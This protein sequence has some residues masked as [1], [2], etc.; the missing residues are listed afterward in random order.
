MLEA[1]QLP[2]IAP[3]GSEKKNASI[4]LWSSFLDGNKKALSS[5]YH[6]YY[7][8]LY[9]YGLRLIH[10]DELIKDSIQ[11]LF[12]YMWE[13]HTS[14]NPVQSVKSY[15]LLSLRRVIFVNIQRDKS[16]YIRNKQ[17]V[18]GMLDDHKNIED[19][20]ISKDNNNIRTNLVK[21]AYSRLSQRQKEVVRM[22]YFEGF[23]TDE[24]CDLLGLK[25]QSVYN[26]LC[27]AITKLQKNIKYCN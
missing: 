22:K 11:E 12:L 18:D 13:H 2:P 16:R 26:C 3:I 1:L 19:L 6:A 17:Y 20:L 9:R 15:L 24:I 8:S 27:E 23:S 7:P 14:L 21:N 4:S 5:L 10:N 25:R